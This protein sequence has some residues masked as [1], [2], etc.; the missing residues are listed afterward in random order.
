MKRQELNKSLSIVVL[1]LLWPI[2]FASAVE[3]SPA[4]GGWL[5]VAKPGGYAFVEDHNDF[6]LNLANEFTIEMWIYL[7]RA[8]KFF[9]SW[10][11]LHKEKSYLL[12]LRGHFIDL[13]GRMKRLGGKDQ[14][15]NIGYY[16]SYPKGGGG[17]ERSYTQ[18]VIPLNRW[19]HLALVFCDNGYLLYINGRGYGGPHIT[20]GPLNNANF[21][22]YIGGTGISPAEFRDIKWVPF[23]GGLIDEVRVSNIARYP[24]REWGEIVIPHRRFEP[25][26]NTMA[27]LHFDGS[28]A[29][30]LKDASGNGH[31]L[32]AFDVAYYHV[33]ISEKL[34]V[35]WGQIKKP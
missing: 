34:P 29:E 1:L 26:E 33:E 10:V 3:H 32:T 20:R 25:D 17:S 6:D 13:D 35:L 4:G 27:L 18:D 19:H 16:Y 9:E 30:W 21:P 11:L 28:R 31:A 14:I 22:L 12:T 5:E 7:K 24:M 23:T 15:C 2:C 8:P